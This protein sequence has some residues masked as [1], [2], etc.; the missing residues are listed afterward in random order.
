MTHQNSG[1]TEVPYFPPSRGIPKVLHQVFLQGW[2]AV[3][4]RIR[5][6]HVPSLRARNRDWEYRFFDAPA[7]ERFIEENYGAGIL[8]VYQSIHPAYY[9]A[10]GDLLRYL[11]IYAQGGAYLDMK[12]DFIRPLDALIRPEDAFLLSKWPTDRTHRYGMAGKHPELSHIPGGEYQQW[13]IIAERGHPLLRAV[14]E[15]V[16]KNLVS[17][18][19]FRDGVGALGV[20]RT[21][22]PIAYTLAIHQIVNQHRHREIKSLDPEMLAYSIFAERDGHKN[23]GHYSFISHPIV[24]QDPITDGVATAYFYIK[25]KIGR[26]GVRFGSLWARVD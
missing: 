10:R 15:R 22:G 14:I 4:A 1:Q 21:T 19:P 5:D 12:S 16:L 2:D 25:R 13:F 24:S 9:A 17:Y 3:P 7:A 6:N 18:R 26:A 20:L 11:I 8:Q 23:A